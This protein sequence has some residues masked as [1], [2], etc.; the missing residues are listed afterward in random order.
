MIWLPRLLD[1]HNY[2]GHAALCKEMQ[3]ISCAQN[4]AEILL[5]RICFHQSLS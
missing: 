1:F 3:G 4:L 2:R 5:R